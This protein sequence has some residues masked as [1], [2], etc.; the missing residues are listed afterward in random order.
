MVEMSYETI[1]ND[2]KQNEILPNDGN[3]LRNHRKR[4]EK[5]RNQA[6]PLFLL[7]CGG[8]R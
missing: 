2:P 4:S 5:K 1:E 8:Q 3:V 6:E 7:L